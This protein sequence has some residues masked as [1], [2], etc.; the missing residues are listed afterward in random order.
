MAR[1]ESKTVVQEQ[2]EESIVLSPPSS[3][4]QKITGNWKNRMPTR[5]GMPVIAG[6][7]IVAA[8]FGGFGYWAATVPIAGAAVS[9]GVIAASGLNQKVEHL[10]GGLISKIL[11]REGDRVSRGQALIELDPTRV[12]AERNR[13]MVSLLGL[14]A[15]QERALAERED[16]QELAFPEEIVESA[17]ESGNRNILE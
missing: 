3:P 6:L 1:K 5:I 15:R 16:L 9:S 7:I 12:E 10:E 17:G 8:F 14:K 11:V 4:K 13:V 2:E